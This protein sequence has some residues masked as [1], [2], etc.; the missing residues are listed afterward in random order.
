MVQL[1]A[2]PRLSKLRRLCISCVDRQAPGMTR[3][4]TAF[5]THET[6]SCVASI[7]RRLVRYLFHSHRPLLEG[8]PLETE[9]LILVDTL[10]AFDVDNL[11]LVDPLLG[12]AVPRRILVGSMLDFLCARAL[13]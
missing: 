12:F 4:D 6:T 2:A 7:F 10:G 3:D 9:G 1:C 11:A 5:V 13:V 8:P